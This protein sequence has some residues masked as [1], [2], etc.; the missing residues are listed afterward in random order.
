L[1]KLSFLVNDNYKQ[2]VYIF[3]TN[4]KLFSV[5]DEDTLVVLGEDIRNSCFSNK[6]TVAKLNENFNKLADMLAEK[7][8]KLYFMPVADKYNLYGDFIVDN[9]YPRSRFFEELRSVPKKYTLIDTKAILLESVRHGEKDVY[10]PDDSHWSWKASEKIFR[11]I[12]F[13]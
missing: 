3:K 11:S 10:Y 13:E 9:P 7:G 12:R 8:I 1:A 4:R 5:T 6:A 2:K